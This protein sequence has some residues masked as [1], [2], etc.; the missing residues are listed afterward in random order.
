M[1]KKEGILDEAQLG[2]DGLLYVPVSKINGDFS[3][4]DRLLADSEENMKNLKAIDKRAKEIAPD[5]IICRY[6]TEPVADGAATYQIVNCITNI[7]DV[8]TEVLIRYCSGICLDNYVHSYFGEECWIGVEYVIDKI[9]A[10]DYFDSLIEKRK[11]QI[12]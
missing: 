12:E 8:I 4:I 11:S 2:K 5:N 1:A 7:N 3:N 9:N 10:R 6:F